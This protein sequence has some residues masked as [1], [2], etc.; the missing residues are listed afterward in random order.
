VT[1][2]TIDDAWQLLQS[3]DLPDQLSSDLSNPEAAVAVLDRL[4]L[5]PPQIS[6]LR[7]QISPQHLQRGCFGNSVRCAIEIAVLDAVCRSA[8]VPLSHVTAL[9]PETEP[10][11]QSVGEVRYSGIIT[12][13]RPLPQLHAALKQRFYGLRQIKVKVGVPGIDDAA[14][15]R[16]IRRVVG[17][18]VDL[19]IDANEAWNCDT[20][21]GT[22]QPLTLAFISCVEQPVP[23]AQVG[24]LA[25]IR[26]ELPIPVMLDESLC[27]LS[28]ARRAI[29]EGLCD[30]FNIRLSKC[31][32]LLPSLRIAAVA[33][34]AGLGF[35]LG[36][37]VGETGILSAAGRRFATSVAGLWYVEGSYDRHLTRERLT[38]EDLT[39]GYGGLAP[40]LNKP[41]LGVDVD[42]A[43]LK[44]V[45]LRSVALMK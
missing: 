32:G 7:S 2:E 14:Q 3:S 4:H 28:D 29:D 9:V 36:C 35:Q 38:V 23:H 5:A 6:H 13:E 40:S 10:F 34:S 26:E 30:L 21:A 37:Q 17:R 11:R 45:T 42:E 41:G 33:A 8:G 20:L 16:R 18:G 31:G 19:R 1:G 27:S 22:L 39:F 24:G 12:A 15:L 25:S 43:A 44:R